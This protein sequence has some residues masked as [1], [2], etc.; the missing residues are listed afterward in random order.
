VASLWIL[1]HRPWFFARVR[2]GLAIVLALLPTVV[3]V[4]KR[5]IFPCQPA[6]MLVPCACAA[7]ACAAADL[8]IGQD[9]HTTLR[10]TE[11]IHEK[12]D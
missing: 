10:K 3:T 4:A 12:T 5:S 8:S 7:A 2:R 6:R 11:V 9:P 1:Q